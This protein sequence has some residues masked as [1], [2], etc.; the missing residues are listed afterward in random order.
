MQRIKCKQCRRCLDDDVHRSTRYHKKCKI[1][2]RREQK[3]ANW[4]RNKEHYR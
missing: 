1:I 2:A 3:L 4:H